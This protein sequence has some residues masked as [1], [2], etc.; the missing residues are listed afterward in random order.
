MRPRRKVTRA[1]K[2]YPRL[3]RA[4]EPHLETWFSAAPEHRRTEPLGT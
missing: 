4:G 3:G 1:F 2:C